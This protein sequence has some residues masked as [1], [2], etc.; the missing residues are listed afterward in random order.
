MNT[1]QIMMVVF[2]I[3]TVLIIVAISPALAN[4]DKDGAE[5]LICEGIYNR[6][7]YNHVVVAPDTGCI[8][9]KVTINGHV[10]AVDASGVVIVNSIVHGNVNMKHISG[11]ALIQNSAV[12]GNVKMIHN[13]N[14]R[15]F[16]GITDNI[17][18]GTVQ[19]THSSNAGLLLADNEIW[20]NLNCNH[21]DPVNGLATNTVHGETNCN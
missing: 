21:N 7:T 2:S 9:N 1:Y 11:I 5:N 16:T 17:I 12:G 4:Q 10:K 3:T 15:F 18:N 20:K 6:G 13:E 14:G 19:F 8:L